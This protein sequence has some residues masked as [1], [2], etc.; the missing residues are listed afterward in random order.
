MEMS[1]RIFSDLSHALPIHIQL[2]LFF[3]EALFLRINTSH[4]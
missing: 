3:E 4:K 1:L 2:I